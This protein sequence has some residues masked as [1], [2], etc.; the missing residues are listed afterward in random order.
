MNRFTDIIFFNVRD[1]ISDFKGYP[2]FFLISRR[3][4]Y[5]RSANNIRD[6]S[7]A[8]SFICTVMM[9]NWFSVLI[10]VAENQIIQ[11]TI[12]INCHNVY[13]SADI[14]FPIFGFYEHRMSYLKDVDFLQ[15]LD[16]ESQI[17]SDFRIKASIIRIM[18]S[19]CHCYLCPMFQW[20]K[21]K[22]MLQ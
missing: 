18:I 6:W 20:G 22:Q 7:L 13:I 3:I 12:Q 15:L 19:A 9:I 4:I 10:S 21:I 16:A 8:Y 11:G 5:E 17:V 14:H 1:C 2:V